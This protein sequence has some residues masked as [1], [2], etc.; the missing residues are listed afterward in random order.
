MPLQVFHLVWWEKPH[1]KASNKY[2]HVSNTS[3]F[4]STGSSVPALIHT[5]RMLFNIK[6]IVVNQITI[7][8]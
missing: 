1:Q 4:G 8:E 5:I 2:F 3:Y 7:L 6:A